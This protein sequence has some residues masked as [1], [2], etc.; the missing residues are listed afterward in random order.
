MAIGMPCSGPTAWPD[1]MALS[2]GLGGE[3]GVGGVDRDEGVELG[4]QPFDAG[5]VFVDQIDGG[6][7]AGGD[8]GG[9]GVDGK[10]SGGGHGVVPGRLAKNIS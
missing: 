8:V 9:Q 4:F 6:E 1:R 7:V 5:Q 10:R 3:P 2:R